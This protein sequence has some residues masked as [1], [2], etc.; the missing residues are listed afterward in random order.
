[1]RVLVYVNEKAGGG[2]AGL[3]EF[4]RLIGLQGAEV[5][6]RYA[7]DGIDPSALVS[8]AADFDRLVVVGGDGTASAISY[9]A[10]ETNVPILVYPAGTANLLA[11][12]LGIPVEPPALSKM[13]FEGTPVRFDLG[14]LDLGDPAHE[15]KRSG[16]VVMAGA[17]YDAAIM[18]GAEPLKPTLGVAAYL[19]AAVT[20]LAPPAA[21]FELELDGERVE[22]DGIAVLLVNFARIQFDLPVTPGSDPRDG[23]FEVA[24]LRSK[25][26]VGIIPA[27]AAAMRD[28]TGDHPDRS[29]SLDVYS[30]ATIT[31]RANPQ[32]KVQCDGD[33]LDSLT[34][35][36][37]RVLPGA[38]TFLVPADSPLAQ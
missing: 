34:P 17:G 5:V 7:R 13:L 35:F 30:A 31:V 33:A 19:V 24:V 3:Y 9:A 38:A 15:G 16:F 6:L 23:V 25:S 14:E 27:V 26:L 21:H 4:V 11:A 36:T 20:N 10:R 22:T 32:L 29:P 8:D 1:M 18:Q 12:N 28:R 2:E 37:A